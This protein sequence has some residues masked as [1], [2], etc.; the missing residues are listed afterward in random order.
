M[1]LEG[2]RSEEAHH[3]DAIMP[4]DGVRQ[5]RWSISGASP[6]TLCSRRARGIVD[7]G[8]TNQRP[9]STCSQQAGGA[10]LGCERIG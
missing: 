9:A 6:S 4:L 3:R 5:G 10:K 2:F 8:A 1:R 7:G